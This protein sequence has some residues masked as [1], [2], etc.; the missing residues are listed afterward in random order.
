[1]RLVLG[2]DV[3]TGRGIDQVLAHP[4]APQLFEG[5]VRD[6]R[7]YVRLAEEAHGPIAAPLAPEALW[8]AALP[9]L[10]RWPGAL[11][12][13]NLETAITRSG[14]PWPGKG[15]HYRMEPA[16]IG[17][18]AAARPDALSLAN[19]HVL[20]WG[21]SGLEETLAALAGAG[22]RCVGAGTALEAATAPLALPVSA[23]GRLVVSAW[24]TSSSGVPAAWAAGRARSGIA[25]LPDL[26]D[27]ALQAVR[28]AVSRVRA[29]G[30]VVLVSLHW[31]GNWGFEIPSAHRDFAHRLVES[32]VADVVHGH[33]SHHPLA[34]EV[35]RGR[36]ILYGC[37]DLVNDY[38]GIAPAGRLRSDV[39]CLYLLALAADGTL[40]ELRIVPLRLRRFCLEEGDADDRAWL[41]RLCMEQGRAFGTG[42]H[43]TA[44]GDFALDWR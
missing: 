30:D 26:G 17:V 1:M 5:W 3:M 11:R 40:Q 37:G 13:F 28:A 16:N 43:E 44:D 23:G 38:E 25:L 18:L 15:I 33:S 19:N 12:I 24:A 41:R 32:G 6:A 31:G 36:A 4:G 39:A 34:I 29:A 2:G 22:L 8:G 10:A 42:V 20:D 7:E 14:A 21:G 35:Y 27:A 9:A